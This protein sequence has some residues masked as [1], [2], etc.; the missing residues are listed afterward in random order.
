MWSFAEIFE[1]LLSFIIVL[2]CFTSQKI[3]NC[4]NY[5]VSE[6]ILRWIKTTEYILRVIIITC[7]DPV[8]RR[9]IVRHQNRED[10]HFMVTKWQSPHDGACDH[11]HC[12][13][14][15]PVISYVHQI[16]DNESNCC[17]VWSLGEIQYTRDKIKFLRCAICPLLYKYKCCQGQ[18]FTTCILLRLKSFLHF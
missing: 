9:Q 17:E 12:H 14:W 6:K 4:Y 5:F 13:G 15:S 16:N 7:N 3:Y 8:M 2:Y 10:T 11:G 18:T 1:K